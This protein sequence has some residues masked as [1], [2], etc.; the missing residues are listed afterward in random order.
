MSSEIEI[1]MGSKNPNT[2]TPVQGLNPTVIHTGKFN[3]DK[4]ILQVSKVGGGFDHMITEKVETFKKIEITSLMMHKL[5]E[6]CAEDLLTERII[7]VPSSINAS[8]KDQLSF[9]YG[10]DARNQMFNFNRDIKYFNTVF[11]FKLNSCCYF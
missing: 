1:K 11:G 8:G 6:A 7:T 3:D 5:L 4:P 10:Y 9:I 2:I